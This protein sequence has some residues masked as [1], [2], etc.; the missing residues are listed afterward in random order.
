MKTR[1]N[2]LMKWITSKGLIWLGFG[3]V[4]FV[5]MACYGPVPTNYQEV[6]LDEEIEEVVDSTASEDIAAEEVVEEDSLNADDQI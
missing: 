3:A 2:R 5:F 4:P 1:M 6:G